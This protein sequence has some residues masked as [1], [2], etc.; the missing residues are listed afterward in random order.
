MLLL[1]LKSMNLDEECVPVSL[2]SDAASQT[3]PIDQV[4]NIR[5]EKTDSE[6]NAFAAAG[7]PP[8]SRDGLFPSRDGLFPLNSSH[9]RTLGFQ[10]SLCPGASR[11]FPTR[12]C[13]AAQAQEATPS[14]QV[15][16]WSGVMMSLVKV[17][18]V[19]T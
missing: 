5:Q 7:K 17:D 18:A 4:Q 6:N 3:F 11:P 12:Q 14:V 8:G 9:P 15:L 16:T 10:I 13:I 2:I 19:Q 1:V